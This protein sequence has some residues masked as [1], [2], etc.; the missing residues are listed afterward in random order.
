MRIEDILRLRLK[1]IV[2]DGDRYRLDITEQKTGKKRVFTVPFPIYEHLQLYALK[3]GIPET[4]R[5]FPVT[6]RAVQKH[7]Q[8]SG[9]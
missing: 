9:I 6:E 1:D 4:A 3:R 2:R 5:L 7:L 8:V